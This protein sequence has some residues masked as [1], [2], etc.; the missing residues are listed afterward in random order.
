[1]RKFA[2]LFPE[3]APNF[4][5]LK[6]IKEKV[7]KLNVVGETFIRWTKAWMFSKPLLATRAWR[8]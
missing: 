5:K 7:A 8:V 6:Q 1:M 4:I 3:E 2:N